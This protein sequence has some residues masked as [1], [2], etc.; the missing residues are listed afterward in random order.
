MI[1]LQ[2]QTSRAAQDDTPGDFDATADN[3]S[4][5]DPGLEDPLA[6]DDGGDFLG[7][8]DSYV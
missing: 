1:R 6:S 7:G 8:D 5:P 2:Q 4:L 3:D